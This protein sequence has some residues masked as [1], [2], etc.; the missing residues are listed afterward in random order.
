LQ[1]L[2]VAK[3][4]AGREAGQ[5]MNQ[6]IEA[7]ADAWRDIDEQAE[8]DEADFQPLS[9]QEAQ[10]WRE[11]HSP[12]SAW[13]IVAWQAAAGFLAAGLA[14]AVS[15]GLAGSVLYGAL[16][17]VLPASLMVWRTA[18]RPANAN[19]ALLRF[20]VWEFLKL[21]LTVTLLLLAPRTANVLNF[22]LNWLALLAGLV[23]A[24]M[25]QLVAGW[26]GSRSR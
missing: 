14:W 2:T 7:K 26:F 12:L 22:G 20:F 19:V 10:Q 25:A 23:V 17:V 9:A 6:R 3:N 8:A 24:L 13:R 5:R 21:V 15:A 18:G 1:K 4:N 16:A 11:R